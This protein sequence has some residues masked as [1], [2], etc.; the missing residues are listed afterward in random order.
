MSWQL[1][2]LVLLGIALAVGFAWYEREQPP[3]RV[4]PLVAALAALA[5][6]GR[7]A[8]AAIPN[9]KPTTDIVLFAGYALGA[10]RPASRSAPSRRSCPTSSSRRARG[11]SGRW[12]DGAR[13]ASA[14]AAARAGRC[15]GASRAASC[16]RSSAARPGSPSAP[17]WT[18]TS[19][20]SPRA[21][22]STHTS[23]SR[24]PH[25]PTTSRT[26]SGTSASAS[27][28]GPR[29]S[30][31]LARYRR[32][33]EVRWAR[34]PAPVA[35]G[36]IAIAL[37]LIVPAR[38]GG[39][40]ARPSARERYLRSAQ[41]RDGGFGGAPG[42]SS[43]PLFSGWAAL[44]AGAAGHNP[45]RREPPGRA[46]ARALTW[47]A[48]G[49]RERDI[50]EVE[51]TAMVLAGSPGA[52]PAQLRRA[53]PDR[54]DRASGAAATARSPGYVSYTAFGIL[55]LRAGGAP[56]AAR[57]PAGSAGPELGR[58]VRRGAVDAER[59]RHDRRGAPG[60]GGHRPRRAAVAQ[61]AVGLP[62]QQQNRDGGFGQ[63]DGRASNSQSTSYAVQGLL[64][65]DAGRRAV[66]AR[67]RPTY[68]AASAATAA[69]PT[70]RRAPDAG[71]GH[72]AGA[73]GAPARAAAARHRAAREA[74]EPGAS[75]T[76]VGGEPADAKGGG[77]RRGG[78][79]E[80]RRRGAGGRGGA[81]A[82]ERRARRG[83][84]ELA[85][86]P[87]SPRPASRRGR[88]RR[89]ARD[90]GGVPAWL[91]DPGGHAVLAALVPFRRRLLRFAPALG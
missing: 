13:W 68:P 55:A 82:P 86:S 65:V 30:A 34:S 64:A 12:P 25:F 85:P 69:W 74:P 42:S 67:A 84:G 8:F 2:S 46:L 70:R 58:R 49:A 51:R 79:R 5:V 3:S 76:P 36:A 60:A 90:G 72:G 41:N 33:F 45:Q 78:R 11:R 17:G 31:R 50:G 53:Q 48:R 59:H 24:A 47:R 15:A 63:M 81:D 1:A 16:S 6:V 4:W 18:S 28:S 87:G 54:R 35:L 43:S 91:D 83:P 77:G 40:D 14:G 20:R 26:R 62:A 39:G 44:G 37:L 73:D 56:A 38:R 27:C 61:R 80:A 57:P 29:S 66:V 21:R 23:L 32:R 52:R 75:A 22:T 7:L 19:G 89:A 9:V 10:D 71:L 88:G